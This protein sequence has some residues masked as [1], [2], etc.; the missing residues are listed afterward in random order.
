MMSL[1]MAGNKNRKQK[2]ISCSSFGRK[3]G[4]ACPEKKTGNSKSKQALVAHPRGSV[5]ARMKHPGAASA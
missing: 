4:N 2:T 3:K 1:A 5:W